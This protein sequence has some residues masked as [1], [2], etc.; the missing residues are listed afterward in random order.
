MCLLAQRIISLSTGNSSVPFRS[1]DI[2]GEPDCSD[3]APSSLGRFSSNRFSR[4]ARILEGT[5]SGTGLVHRR[6]ACR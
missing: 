1:S 4:S 2:D 6:D 3:R 5:P